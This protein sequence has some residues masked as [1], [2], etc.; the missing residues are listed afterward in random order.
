MRMA[1]KKGL[2]SFPYSSFSELIGENMINNDEIIRL[3]LCSELTSH[4]QHYLKAMSID[5]LPLEWDIRSNQQIVS[6][7]F[8]TENAPNTTPI[9]TALTQSGMFTGVSIV[10][11][12]TEEGKSRI[13]LKTDSFSN[14]L[15]KFKHAQYFNTLIQILPI[16]G[17][18]C[19][20]SS[21]S[22]QLT[23][24][25]CNLQRNSYEQIPNLLNLLMIYWKELSP[26][27]IAISCQEVDLLINKHR[28]LCLDYLIQSIKNIDEGS[29]NFMSALNVE[30]FH[31]NRFGVNMNYSQESWRTTPGVLFQVKN[32]KATLKKFEEMHPGIL[33]VKVSGYLM[34]KDAVMPC[35][36]KPKRLLDIP[37]IIKDITL[38]SM[39]QSRSNYLDSLLVFKGKPKD[40]GFSSFPYEISKMILLH[41]CD[42]SALLTAREKNEHIDRI[43]NYKLS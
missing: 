36:I 10:Q 23:I 1:D 6:N 5:C 35:G 12:R 18:I 25:A 17:V 19:L 43:A 24:Q 27:K 34:F 31:Q 22:N 14:L 16:S 8:L 37:F 39:R 21:Q 7:C 40:Y 38:A 11:S 33:E 20:P 4:I 3:T 13:L 29:E 26:S 28:Q 15:D 32:K 30:Y 2:I 42:D 9:L 41:V